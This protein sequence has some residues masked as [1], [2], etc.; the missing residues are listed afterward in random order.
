[1]QRRVQGLNAGYVAQLLEDYLDSPAS[2]PHEWRGS[3]SRTRTASPGPCSR[4]SRPTAPRGRRRLRAR[5][6]P[7]SRRRHSGR[8]RLA[9]A[10][11]A[12]CGRPRSCS[13]ASR[14]RWRS[15]RRTAC[16]GISR[17]GSIRSAR[18][19]LG[20]P[21]LDETRLEP[22][23]TPELQARIPARLLRLYVARRDA[24]RGAPAVARGLLRLDRVRDRAHLRPRGARLA[25]PGDRVRALPAAS[26]TPERAPR[27]A[28]AADAGRGLR[29]YLRKSFLGQKQFSLEGLDVLVPM[30]DETIELAAA[31]GAHEVVIGMAHRGRLN[32]LAHTVGRS[33]ES[34]LREFEGE[35]TDDAL[36]VDPEGGSGDVKYHLPASGTRVTD[37]GEIEVD[38]RA[39]PEPSRGRRPGRR[40][41]G[42]RRADRPLVGRRAPRPDGR[43]AGP[44][45][46]R[47][48]VR[49]A[50]HRRRDAQPAEP[51]G[52]LDGR[53]PAPDHEQ[54]GRLHDRPDGRP[55][56]ALLERPREGVRRADRP[57]QRRRPGGGA[58]A[59]CASRSPIGRSSATTS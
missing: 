26:P 54:P 32:A 41:L 55:L 58:R 16:T 10:R 9:E 56:D 4:S 39:E 2:V 48:G 37:G 1:M 44:H 50:G 15:S 13:A 20:D 30:L 8:S 43:A 47:R 18:S 33:Y 51:R 59:R 27:A 6:G 17:R 22:P 5:R 45:P 42:A 49:R 25:A 57:R 36:V 21:A 19:R 28:A 24:A 35:R 3:S 40:G 23:L 46:R 53:H 31:D 7:R 14:R 38:D 52:L 29:A 12:G 34:I 11:R